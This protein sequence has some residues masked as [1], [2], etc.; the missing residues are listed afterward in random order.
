MRREM[1]HLLGSRKRVRRS[2]STHQSGERLQLQLIC[3]FGEPSMTALS[4]VTAPAPAHLPFLVSRA[5]LFKN[6]YV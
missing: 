5:W 4:L 2:P 1:Q 6:F 3:P